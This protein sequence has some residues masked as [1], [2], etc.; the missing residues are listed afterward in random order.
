MQRRN[1]LLRELFIMVQTT[2]Q[3]M[4][5]VP[6]GCETDDGDLQTFLEKFDL[7]KE[8][9]ECLCLLSFLS[10]FLFSPN[11][12]SI[13]NF[14]EDDFSFLNRLPLQPS[15]PDF[16]LT[17]LTSSHIESVQATTHLPNES[18]VTV[19][20]REDIVIPIPS[21]QT[22]HEY[23]IDTLAASES[24]EP[25]NSPVYYRHQYDPQYKLP[26]L[27]VLPPEF[28][29]KT[30]TSKRKK[31]R[32]RDKSDGKKDRDEVLPLGVNRWA[33]TVHANPVWK[34]VSRATKCLSSREWGVCLHSSPY[35]E[36][37]ADTPNRLPFL[38]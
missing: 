1:D 12:G 2:R 14:K 27:S 4:Q 21:K 16:S 31:E 8:C 30:K 26:P 24:L 18:M 17:S 3:D 15:K 19:D 37:T 36:S 25:S 11:Q 9:V 33:A 23:H 5:S 13:A 38:N 10:Y 28:V 20:P 34:K 6:L 22:G 29:R 35:P 7:N 32:E